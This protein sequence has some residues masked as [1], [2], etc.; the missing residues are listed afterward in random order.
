M[1]NQD[2]ITVKGK[3]T[4]ALHGCKFLVTTEMGNVVNAHLSGKLKINKIKIYEGD[5]VDVD[6][7][8]M[9]KNKGIITWRY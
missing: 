7:S 8:V 2:F 3:V 9:D 5:N 6:I 4:E 1:S